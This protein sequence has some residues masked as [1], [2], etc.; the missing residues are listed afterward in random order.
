MIQILHH[1]ASGQFTDRITALPNHRLYRKDT[2]FLYPTNWNLIQVYKH[3]NSIYFPAD[4]NITLYYYQGGLFYSPV[5]TCTGNRCYLQKDKVKASCDANFNLKVTFPRPVQGI[6]VRVDGV[7]YPTGKEVD[8]RL[9]STFENVLDMDDSKSWLSSTVYYINCSMSME[10]IMDWSQLPTQTILR[11]CVRYSR[12]YVI[13]LRRRMRLRPPNQMAAS[14]GQTH[15]KTLQV[16]IHGLENFTENIYEYGLLVFQSN[17]TYRMCTKMKLP[18]HHQRLLMLGAI[19]TCASLRTTIPILPS[20]LTQKG[21]FRI[22]YQ[23]FQETQIK[24]HQTKN[25]YSLIQSK[26]IRAH[27]IYKWHSLETSSRSWKHYDKNLKLLNFTSREHSWLS[28]AQMC[29]KYGMTLSHLMDEKSTNQL[30]LYLLEKYILPTYALFVGLVRKVSMNGFEDIHGGRTYFMYT[31][32]SWFKQRNQ[33]FPNC[34]VK[35]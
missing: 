4:V 11:A 22:G 31:F 33:F 7:A 13:D 25:L 10:E 15:L 8:E 5:Q 29:H 2:V 24:F 26:N 9:F 6:H 35:I 27:L 16:S 34:M 12:K 14:S 18:E 32:K 3:N 21:S 30:V 17:P 1:R 19:K 20:H 23:V 28:A